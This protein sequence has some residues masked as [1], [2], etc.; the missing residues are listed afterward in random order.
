LQDTE[1][2]FVAADDMHADGK[3]SG[4]KPPGTEAAG[5]PVAEMYQQAF[6]QSM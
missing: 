3:P 6:I 1:I 5:F 2:L 4:V